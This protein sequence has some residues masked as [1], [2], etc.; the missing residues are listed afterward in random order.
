MAEPRLPAPGGNVTRSEPLD[1]HAANQAE[2][3]PPPSLTAYCAGAGAAGPESVGDG[4]GIVGVGV[5]GAGFTGG[6]GDATSPLGGMDARGV[7]VRGSPEDPA[8]FPV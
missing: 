7:L 4:P 2:K 5:S 1:N 6:G 8:N 3:R